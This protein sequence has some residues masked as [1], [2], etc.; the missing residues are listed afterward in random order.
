M[1]GVVFTEFLEMMDERFGPEVTERVIE[2]CALA[3]G[4]A[5]TAVGTYDHRELMALVS[6]LGREVGLGV[7]DLMKAYGRHLF[8]RFVRLYPPFFQGVSS[9]FQF[10]EQVDSHIHVEVR[11]LYPEAELPSFRASRLDDRHLDL[12]YRSAR[13]FGDFA[14]GLI[15]GCGDHFGEN[16]SIA[17]E[18][19]DGGEGSAIRFHITRVE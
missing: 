1:K 10:L 5:Y 18:P 19:L 3:G 6:A 12:D 7:P 15:L 8:G 14:E 4:G 13:P 2:A 9:A 17:R 11:K 16:L